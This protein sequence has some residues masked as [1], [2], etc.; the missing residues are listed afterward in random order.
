MRQ[1]APGLLPAPEHTSSFCDTVPQDRGRRPRCGVRR[2]TGNVGGTGAAPVRGRIA[3]LG[4]ASGEA[5]RRQRGLQGRVGEGT[6]PGGALPAGPP[7]VAKSLH[8]VPAGPR[9]AAGLPSARIPKEVRAPAPVRDGGK[10]CMRG[11]PTVAMPR[12]S[13]LAHRV[14]TA[15]WHAGP[16]A[17]A[18]GAAA[19]LRGCG[20][21]R[22]ARAGPRPQCRR[23][24]RRGGHVHD[25]P[26][27]RRGQIFAR[28]R[29]PLPSVQGGAPLEGQRMPEKWGR[30]RMT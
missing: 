26:R 1:P 11:R 23:A 10:S 27:S 5:R 21:R 9:P 29:Q 28:K 2:M 7:G 30:V 14:R 4:S 19:R 20:T 13:H 17:P 25:G 16:H 12:L 8:A 6:R 3:G 15:A 24:G 18:K 22:P